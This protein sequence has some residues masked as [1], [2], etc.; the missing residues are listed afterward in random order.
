MEYKI[1][2]D[3]GGHN[4]RTALIRNGK[5]IK[6]YKRKTEVNKGKQKIIKNILESIDLVKGNYKIKGIGIVFW[7]TSYRA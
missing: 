2:I 7:N 1:A 4:I 3:F 5:I 6:K